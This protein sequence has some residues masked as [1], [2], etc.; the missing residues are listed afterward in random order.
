ME[1]FS[2]KKIKRIVVVLSSGNSE[3]KTALATVLHF[4]GLRLTSPNIQN[5]NG[6]KEDQYLKCAFLKAINPLRN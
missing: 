6:R 5:L 1:G 4:I 3:G 2:K